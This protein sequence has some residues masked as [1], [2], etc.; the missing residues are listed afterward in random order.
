MAKEAME[1]DNN[2]VEKE[3]Q[4]GERVCLAKS[5]KRMGIIDKDRVSH[6]QKLIWLLQN[7][8]KLKAKMRLDKTCVMS[9]AQYHSE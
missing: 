9:R 7:T 8:Y 1:H 4:R 3:L 6:L 5:M 2:E